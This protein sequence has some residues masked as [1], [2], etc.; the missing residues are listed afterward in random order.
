MVPNASQ[1][2]YRYRQVLHQISAVYH[3][4]RVAGCGCIDG[5]CSDPF[6]HQY[7]HQQTHFANPWIGVSAK[8]NSRKLSLGI[9]A[10]RWSLSTLPHLNSLRWQ[11]PALTQKLKARPGLF[12]SV[13]T[14]AEA[15]FSREMGFCFV[16]PTKWSN[17]LKDSE[18]LARSSARS[19]ATPACAVS[20]KRCRW[21]SSACKAA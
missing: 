9:L 5:L 14:R 6:R 8:W 10:P 19:L 1:Y 15:N 16:R 17:W 11:A 20:P 13:E 18:R 7:G 3:C 21:L 2:R 12:H 4:V